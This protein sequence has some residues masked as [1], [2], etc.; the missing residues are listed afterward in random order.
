MD[1]LLRS[2]EPMYM[3]IAAEL[4]NKIV[5]GQL[6]PGDTLPSENELRGLYAASRETVRKSLKELE[7]E[8]YIYSRPARGISSASRNTAG[9][10]WSSRRT[11]T[12]CCGTSP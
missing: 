9:S 4:K 12:R 6:C 2:G 7:N 3:A 8:G 11:R 1:A 10:P 5:S